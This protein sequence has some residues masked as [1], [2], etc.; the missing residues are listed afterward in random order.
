MAENV[1]E[2]PVEGTTVVGTGAR[3]GRG[4]GRR[5]GAYGLVAV[6]LIAV[7]LGGM[8]VHSRDTTH[9]TAPSI[10]HTV[11]RAEPQFLAN[12]ASNT[13]NLPNAVSIDV[14]PIVTSSQQ[15]YLDVNTT[16]LPTSAA[17]SVMPGG[18]RRFLDVNTVML[19][20][21]PSYPYAED[22]TPLPGHHR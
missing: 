12:K 8:A 16:W 17:S 14:R 9:R 4:R 18:E 21:G 20:V 19:P 22:V 3:R 2:M 5:N 6:A 15:K 1:A 10:P 13:T 7:V 11:T